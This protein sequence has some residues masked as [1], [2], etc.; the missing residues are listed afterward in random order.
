MSTEPYLY[1]GSPPAVQGGGASSAASNPYSGQHRYAPGAMANAGPAAASAAVEYGA[2]LHNHHHQ[3]QQRRRRESNAPSDHTDASKQRQLSAETE[4]TSED[5]IESLKRAMGSDL[6]ALQKQRMRKEQMSKP[7]PVEY[8]MSLPTLVPE[9][10]PPAMSSVYAGAA[11]ASQRHYYPGYLQ[12]PPEMSPPVPQLPEFAAQEWKMADG[13][14]S[15]GAI[16]AHPAEGHMQSAFSSPSYLVQPPPQQQQQQQHAAVSHAYG[17]G[18]ANGAVA[19]DP[20]QA[21]PQT[22]QQLSDVQMFTT[23]ESAAYAYAA[24]TSPPM[25]TTQHYAPQL[26]GVQGAHQQS[27]PY[28]TPQQVPQPQLHHHPHAYPQHWTDAASARSNDQ[29]SASF[30]DASG[31]SQAYRAQGGNPFA[32]HEARQPRS[33]AMAG[34]SPM[35]EQ[36][37][38]GAAAAAVAAQA[39]H[40]TEGAFA[41][42]LDSGYS[43]ST[44]AHNAAPMQ[45]M[46]EQRSSPAHEVQSAP[47]YDTDPLDG[48]FTGPSTAPAIPIQSLLNS[49]E[50]PSV[51]AAE[52]IHQHIANENARF[53]RSSAAS[54]QQQLLHVHD[55]PVPAMPAATAVRAGPADGSSP[56][57]RSSYH[58]AGYSTWHERAETVNMDFATA[59]QSLS[60]ADG[61]GLGVSIAA[62]AHFHTTAPLPPIPASFALASTEPPPVPAQTEPFGF[63]Y[64]R[65]RTRMMHTSGSNPAS[66]LAQAG[67]GSQGDTDSARSAD[68]PA[69]DVLPPAVINPGRKGTAESLDNVLEYYRSNPEPLEPL[70]E[71][72]AP[73][74][75]FP[76]LLSSSL[77]RPELNSS[78]FPAHVSQQSPLQRTSFSSPGAKP[79]D[80]REENASPVTSDH[81]MRPA[82]SS[83]LGTHSH[84]HSRESTP[85]PEPSA[86]PEMGPE[87]S[88]EP[89]MEPEPLRPRA[90]SYASS[91]S[92]ASSVD[93]AAEA[94]LPTD[95]AP[96]RWSLD[97]A[98]CFD[99]STSAGTGLQDIYATLED[100]PE[101]DDLEL[102]PTTTQQQQQQQQQHL[103]PSQTS[104]QTS[105][106]HSPKPLPMDDDDDV[107]QMEAIDGI[108]ELSEI[109]DFSLHHSSSDY[110]YSTSNSSTD[111]F[112]EPIEHTVG[113]LSK[114]L[115][116]TELSPDAQAVPRTVT[117]PHVIHQL[118][119]AE[120]G[121]RSRVGT[122]MAQPSPTQAS[123]LASFM[124]VA[125][126]EHNK[127]QLTGTTGALAAA[128]STT[129]AAASAL[130]S[131]PA[132]TLVPAPAAANTVPLEIMDYASE[133]EISLAREQED[134]YSDN[135]SQAN[136]DPMILQSLGKAVHQQCLL[137]RQQVQR[138]KSNMHLGLT[139]TN[140]GNAS[141]E[142]YTD[143]G[144][145]Q[146][147]DDYEQALRAML[148]EVSQYFTQSGLNQ[149]FPF[150]AKWVDWL[151][152]HPD[153][154]FPWRKETDDDARG[155]D[156]DDDDDDGD[157]QSDVSSFG[158]D[159]PML[160][161]PL[162]P[163]DVL[164]KATIPM[165]T[166]R[167]V[168]VKDF[169][170]QE[171]RKGINAHWQY[172]SVINQITVVA[173]NI[174]RTLAAPLG[175]ADHS[176]VPHQL[177]ALYQFLGGDF[178]KYKPS[179]ESIFDSVKVSLGVVTR[180]PTPLDMT[181]QQQQQQQEGAVENA[182]D[183]DALDGTENADEEHADPNAAVK[184]PV[185]LL[186]TNYVYLLRDMMASIITE[187][188]YST[189][190]VA[191]NKDHQPQATTGNGT[192]RQKTETAGQDTVYAIS[193]LKGLPTQS[194]VRYLSKEMRTDISD[195]IISS[196][197][198]SNHQYRLYRNSNLVTIV[199]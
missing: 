82:D 132:P 45:E 138:R 194:I 136:L 90:C 63:D 50:Q 60:S 53:H 36:R 8:P 31:P 177:A 55:L 37:Y 101:P 79:V 65:S 153:R 89:E 92:S 127:P 66:I 163:E 12:R 18:Y 91:S 157:S 119:A 113:I 114:P 143:P 176:S 41:A 32:A 193:T 71:A 187:A 184:Q 196:S 23:A 175:H 5:E 38:A 88:A 135:V 68:E 195:T 29:M 126:A 161:R 28:Q 190:P 48:V 146:E 172:Y 151:T 148:A 164:N 179:I 4:D 118:G 124:E 21:P 25:A 1:K 93:S 145:A 26:Y 156:E 14:S 141:S 110:G 116:A 20:R 54:S 125:G 47:L 107:L 112:G 149:V 147:Y 173:S 129:S 102:P 97:D 192:T 99:F 117:T 11:S 183:I 94:L 51:S 34:Q 104:K 72:R 182:A 62:D 67:D 185:R 140:G 74:L 75:A 13:S 35:A 167:P 131:A 70:P 40:V 197:I 42:G 174:H 166:R 19:I 133:L 46:Q 24:V 180:P 64:Y 134:Y 76:R 6:W 44:T 56:A 150:S 17:G 142:D 86:E 165:S 57:S 154:P 178:K 33:P 171:K 3:Q 98:V 198:N 122:R 155:P 84:L 2:L 15:A 186:D 108:S 106:L 160:S 49:P 30:T 109:L 22:I 85:D 58:S 78:H 80:T 170:S 123:H 158:E 103:Q 121:T 152:R 96:P 181:Q 130:A 120:L 59:Q 189:S 10:S 69:A 27:R 100:L 95:V 139:T 169:V 39:E 115:A 191:A 81:G 52:A 61:T 144:A 105:T 7:A 43:I 128:A 83:V 137:Q 87:P 16:A 111:S 188:L 77:R 199:V 159:P 9:A 168:L 162:P 73:D